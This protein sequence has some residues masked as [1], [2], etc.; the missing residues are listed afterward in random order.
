MGFSLYKITSKKL[1]VGSSTANGIM[2]FAENH[3]TRINVQILRHL[4]ID[5][6]LT[7]LKGKQ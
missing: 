4:A 5:S 6:E 7:I 3:D 2:K 1:S